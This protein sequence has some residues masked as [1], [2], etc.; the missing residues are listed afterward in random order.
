MSFATITQEIAQGFPQA[1]TEPLKAHPLAK[2]IEH[3]WREA[4]RAILPPSALGAFTLD[5]SAG[6]GAWNAAPWLAV[7]HPK[8]TQSARA[9]FYPVYLF[10]PR[11]ET[12][13]L[14]LGQGAASLEEAVGK[15]AALTELARRAELL[16]VRVANWADR[17]FSDGPFVT[18]RK[19]AVANSTEADRDP[20][21][22][23]VAFGK[24]YMISAMPSDQE[25]ASD[26]ERMLNI[27]SHLV[28]KGGLDFAT[29][30]ADLL[31]L[32]RTG[33]LPKGTVDGAKQVLVHKR[34]EFRKR[35]SK[36]IT[37]VKK[38]LGYTCAACAFNFGDIYG[39]EMARYIEA[40]H[41]VPISTVDEAG[42][43]LSPTEDHFAVL[44]SNCHRAIHA[45]GCPSLPDFKKRLQR[46][47]K[48][49][50]V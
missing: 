24:R 13:C 49:E 25:L 23:A 2:K 27:Y 18:L 39:D 26:L 10:E 34:V 1:K 44:C 41:L 47:L 46:K 16:R 35:N 32:K 42:V 11:F 7:F 36:L 22:A 28:S 37:D 45:A 40:H 6:I 14:V 15:K 30:D 33:E 19:A 43:E 20:W 17:G 21:S 12:V 9:G 50:P 38:N 3:G 31:D 5:S 29:E 4:L 48:F 8:V